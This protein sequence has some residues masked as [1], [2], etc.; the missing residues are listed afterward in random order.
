MKS[1]IR[2]AAQAD[3]VRYLIDAMGTARDSWDPAW[4]MAEDCVQNPVG[5]GGVTY[6][7]PDLA[8][9]RGAQAVVLV[10]EAY[11]LA[12]RVGLRMT[13]PMIAGRKNPLLR[14]PTGPHSVTEIPVP[15]VAEPRYENWDLPTFARWAE[16]QLVRRG[17][18][19]RKLATYKADSRI[20][21]QKYPEIAEYSGFAYIDRWRSERA[22]ATRTGRYWLGQAVSHVWKPG[23]QGAIEQ[24]LALARDKTGEEAPKF[25][26]T[27]IW[28][29]QDGL[30]QARFMD[31]A[32]RQ[33]WTG[34]WSITPGTGMS[35]LVLRTLGISENVVTRVTPPGPAAYSADEGAMPW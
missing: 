23:E 26:F 6:W 7:E 28:W 17:A 12:R 22:S 24:L 3:P 20:P 1:A 2:H 21:A 31:T 5:Y 30:T 18:G 27:A 29:P 11:D 14:T 34:T 9:V 10:V 4:L 33:E 8:E 13:V 15:Q 25:T 32:S 35:N 16:A 19:T